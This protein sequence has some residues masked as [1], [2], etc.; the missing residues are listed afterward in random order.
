MNSYKLNG[1]A[2]HHF[3]YAVCKGLG[4]QPN[5]IYKEIK[6]ISNEGTILTKDGRKFKL[7]IKEI[8]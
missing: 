4:I 7:Q 5:E 8:H 1:I 2:G 6:S 3:R